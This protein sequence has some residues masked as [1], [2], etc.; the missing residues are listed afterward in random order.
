ML[1]IG[2]IGDIGSGKTTVAEMF[3]ECGAKVLNV[4]RIAHRLLFRNGS[5]FNKTVQVF[6]NRILKKGRISRK[7][8]GEIVFADLEK[9]AK[10]ERIVHP[11][12]K[13][14]IRCVLLKN[15]RRRVVII[16]DFPLLL[17]MGFRRDCDLVVFVD[18][19]KSLSVQRACARMGI[20]RQQL[21]QRERNQ[22]IIQEKMAGADV[23]VRNYSNK[24]KTK[25]QV[26]DIWQK[27]QQI[28]KK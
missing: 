8:L 16:L 14:Q 25:K 24:Q 27:V 15:Q 26:R 1:V 11:Q 2:I 18:A 22:K 5:C 6:G 19:P 3:R 17:E 13:K 7:I 12:L 4:D 23:I 9:L 28:R 20:A 21:R 10:L